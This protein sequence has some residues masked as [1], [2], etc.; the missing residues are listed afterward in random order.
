MLQDAGIAGEW[1]QFMA[2]S[3]SVN[4]AKLWKAAGHPMDRTTLAT[5]TVDGYTIDIDKFVKRQ[6]FYNDAKN[7]IG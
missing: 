1:P 3:L 6:Q 7:A 5:L 4:M 2:Y